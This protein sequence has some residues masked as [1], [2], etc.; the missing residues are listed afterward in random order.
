LA[1]AMKLRRAWSWVSS[2][3]FIVAPYPARRE[4]AMVQSRNDTD[5]RQVPRHAIASVDKSAAIRTKRGSNFPGR[6]SYNPSEMSKRQRRSGRQMSYRD[7]QV[8]TLCVAMISHIAPRNIFLTDFAGDKF[9]IR[10]C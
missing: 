3:L 7:E 9:V 6:S 2:G 8:L 1:L 4:M 10:F 5:D